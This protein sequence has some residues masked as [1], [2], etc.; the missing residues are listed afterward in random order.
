MKQS[1]AKDHCWDKGETRYQ[2][3]I[4]NQIRVA[5]TG[6][7]IGLIMLKIAVKAS[8]RYRAVTSASSQ[9]LPS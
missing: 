3:P 4:K 9:A 8:G 7:M 6:I 5:S 1:E 2:H